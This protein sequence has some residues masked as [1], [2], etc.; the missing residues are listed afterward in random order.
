MFF[1]TYSLF[2]WRRR[3]K[4]DE[5]GFDGVDRDFFICPTAAHPGP[6]GGRLLE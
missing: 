5:S 4:L 2:R 1:I 3:P 6:H